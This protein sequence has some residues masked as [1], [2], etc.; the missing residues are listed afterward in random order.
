MPEASVEC[1]A[2]EGRFLTAQTPFGMRGV[3]C[4]AKMGRSSA[5]PLQRQTQEHSHS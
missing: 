2:R 4:V 3:E 5:A 1:G